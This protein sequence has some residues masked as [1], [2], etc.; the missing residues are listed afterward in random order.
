MTVQDKGGLPRGLINGLAPPYSLYTVT[1]VLKI[2]FVLRVVFRVYV[3]W[4]GSDTY[5]VFR[6][7]FSPT[8]DIKILRTSNELE[9]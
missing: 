8:L 9:C 3:Y 4:S 5:P 7:R 6:T 2:L 1:S